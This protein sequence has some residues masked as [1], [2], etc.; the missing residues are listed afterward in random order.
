MSTFTPVSTPPSEVRPRSQYFNQQL[1]NLFRDALSLQ[2]W[3]FL[4]ALLQSTLFLLIP[5]S[6]AILPVILYFTICFIDNALIYSGIRPNPLMANIIPGKT[7]AQFPGS[8]IPSQHPIVVIKLAARTN[9]P[10][11]I[12]HPHMRK[13]GTYFNRMI[14]D[15]DENSEEY[16]YLGA[17]SYLANE[18][19]TGNE[20]MIMA[21]FRTYDGLHAFSHENGVH[22]EAWNYW[23]TQVMGR[24]KNEEGR[25]FSIM[26]EAYEV[27]VGKW[28][29]IFIN[30]HPSGVAATTFK[31][32]VDGKEKWAS[33]M[34]DARKGLFRTSKGRMAASAGDENEI[35]G[36][37]PYANE[38]A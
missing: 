5:T 29:N 17:N 16:G 11:G 3:L 23:N 24:G 37:D 25:M 19:S 8:T 20:L 18:R 4:G 33:P 14:D 1:H 31:V 2:T 15:L 13:I 30:Y 32:D 35:Y 12:I 28:E 38:K 27:P 21:Y 36:N 6:I 7:S 10:L 9:H 34:V 26:H 22:R